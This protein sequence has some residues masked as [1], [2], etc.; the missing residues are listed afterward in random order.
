MDSGHDDETDDDNDVAMTEA[1][2][3]SSSSNERF[4]VASPAD[5]YGYGGIAMIG[6]R[7]FGGFNTNI[8]EAWSLSQETAEQMSKTAKS[9][10]RNPLLSDKELIRRVNRQKEK[11]PRQG[12]TPSPPSKNGSSSKKKMRYY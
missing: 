10:K 4:E 6:R 3:Y 8:A 11:H 2:S 5:I 9:S 12:S 7:S 1:A